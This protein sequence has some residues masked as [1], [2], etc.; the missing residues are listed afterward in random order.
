MCIYVIQIAIY[1]LRYGCSET[2][3]IIGGPYYT[4]KHHGEDGSV[5]F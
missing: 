2:E 5:K 4:G 3:A 1:S